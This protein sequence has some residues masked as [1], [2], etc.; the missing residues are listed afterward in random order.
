MDTA[1]LLRSLNDHEVRY[2]VIGAAAFPVH[3]YA[4]ATLDIDIFI[5][6]DPKNVEK[7]ILALSSF[8]YDLKDITDEDLRTKKVLIRQYLLET[9]IHPFV[10]GASFSEVWENKVE[11]EIG[12]VGAYFASLDDLIRMKNAAGRPK[13]VEDLKILLALKNEKTRPAPDV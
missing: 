11:S 1:G 10:E 7:V 12:G 6:P 8:G 9:D 2:V 3:G 13:D 4:R 5:D